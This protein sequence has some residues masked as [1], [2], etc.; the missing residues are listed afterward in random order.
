MDATMNKYRLTLSVALLLLA[1]PLTLA[2]RQLPA[3]YPDSFQHMGTIDDINVAAEHIVILDTMMR[4]PS[5]IPVHTPQ[6][7]LAHVN[8]LRRGMRVGFSLQGMGNQRMVTE[9]WVLPDRYAPA[10]EE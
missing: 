6:Q 9:I 4:L 3:H 7:P 8:G 1:L 10:G 5:A 2:A